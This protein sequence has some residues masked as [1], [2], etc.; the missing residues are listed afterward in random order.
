[1]FQSG[2]IKLCSKEVGSGSNIEERVEKIE[3]YLKS[4]KI[5]VSS[6][7]A[8]SA[9]P[10]TGVAQSA[11]IRDNNVTSQVNSADS[12]V[13]NVQNV[14]AISN[15]SNTNKSYSSDLSKSWPKIVNDLRQNGKIVLYTNLM[16][17]QAEKINDNTVGIKFKNGMT[18]FGKTVLEKQENVKEISSLVSM[19]CGK[20]VQIKYISEMQNEV[21]S[22]TPEEDIQ[23]LASESDI[24]FNIIE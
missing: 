2:I 22:T 16:N 15:T 4:G 7:M 23:K 9:Q 13:S 8:V 18:A 1:M 17:T 6:T 19:A 3:D 21:V 11:T 12:R 10:V 14:K 20:D 5:A 24:P